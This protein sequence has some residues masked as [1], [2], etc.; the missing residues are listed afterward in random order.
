VFKHESKAKDMF[1]SS[2]VFGAGKN[3]IVRAALGIRIIII[4]K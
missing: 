2:E 1:G 4:V 3:Y